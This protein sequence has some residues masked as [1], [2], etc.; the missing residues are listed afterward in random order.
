MNTRKFKPLLFAS[1]ALYA[2]LAVCSSSAAERTEQSAQRT[3]EQKTASAANGATQPSDM[4]PRLLKAVIR[5]VADYFGVPETD[6]SADTNLQRDLLAGHMDIYEVLAH[7]CDDQ[8]REMVQGVTP[9]MVRI[10]Q[11]VEYVRN[12]PPRLRTSDELVMRGKRSSVKMAGRARQSAAEQDV[13]VQ[14][15]FYAT[16]RQRTADN[17]WQAMFSGERSPKGELYYGTCLVSIP[18]GHVRGELEV[19]TGSWR[20]TVKASPRSYFVLQKVDEIGWNAFISRIRSGLGAAKGGDPTE[21]DVLIFIHGYNVPFHRAA[22]RTAQI[23]FDLRFAGAPILFSW[24]SKGNP[25]FYFSDREA[26]EWSVPYLER[27]LKDVIDQSGARRLHLIAHSM[28]NQGLIRALYQVALRSGAEKRPLFEN[29]IMAAPDFD[30]RR[31]TEQIAPE[32]IPLAKRWTLY[33]SDK[34]MAL[35]ASDLLRFSA[36][37]RLGQPLALVR[38]VDTIDASGFEVSPWN[39]AENH[40][41]FATKQLVITD[42]QSVLKGL[43]PDSRRLV[44]AVKDRIVYWRLGER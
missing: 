12:T 39:L 3:I 24:P 40:G 7:V 43:A 17:D 33:E 34:D 37:Q 29:V 14:E 31:F 28:G 20:S 4:N 9:D 36:S 22:L 15:V 41:Y 10:R 27:F 6:L 23:A 26:V 1:I 32:V 35:E 11:L 13:F 30:S 8:D 42:V 16:N 19:P 2:F 38:G 44:R 25:F 18:K 5:A 21:Q